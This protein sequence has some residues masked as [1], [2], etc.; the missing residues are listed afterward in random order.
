MFFLS[1]SEVTIGF[2]RTLYMVGEDNGYIEVCASVRAGSLQASA[3]VTVASVDGTATGEFV[4][5]RIGQHVIVLIF[6]FQFLVTIL[7]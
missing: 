3:V 7:V 1:P 2:E 4:W 5:P 6:F